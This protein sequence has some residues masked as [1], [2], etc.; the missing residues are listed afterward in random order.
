MAQQGAGMQHE[1]E[2]NGQPGRQLQADQSQPEIGV[3]P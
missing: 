1:A 3:L 2:G